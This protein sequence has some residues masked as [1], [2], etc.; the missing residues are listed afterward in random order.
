MNVI[1]HR[2]QSQLFSFAIVL[3]LVQPAGAQSPAA[4]HIASQVEKILSTDTLRSGFQ[5]VSIVRVDTGE[6]LCRRLSWHVFTPASNNKLLTSTG[7]LGILGSDFR[8]KTRVCASGNVEDSILKGNITLIGSGDP[9]L[10]TANLKELAQQTFSAGIHH[11]AGDVVA[12]V[13]CFDN[14]M[15]GTS[16]EWDDE[17]FYYAAQISGLNVDRNVAQVTIT[18]GKEVGE[19]PEV[20]VAPLVNLFEV[21]NYAV[22]EDTADHRPHIELTRERAANTLLI[23]GKIPPGKVAELEPVTFERPHKVAT[24]VFVQEFKRLGGEVDATVLPSQGNLAVIAEHISPPLSEILTLMNKPS[25][26]MIA[27]CLFKAVGYAASRKQGTSG[28]SGTSA[29]AIRKLLIGAGMK[30]EELRQVDGSGMARQNQISPDNL[31]RLLCWWYKRPEFLTLYASL[32]QAGVDG[33]LKS[34]MKGTSASGNCRAKTGSLTG[35]SCL[36]G[37]V[38]SADGVL[39]AFSIMTNAQIG[40]VRPCMEAQNRIVAMLA[41]SVIKVSGTHQTYSH[42]K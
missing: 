1:R 14:Q 37:Y 22:T 17:Q 25:D 18:G 11:I 27:E 36:S 21:K 42:R 6:P 9:V 40:S 28:A 34:R 15:L 32:P 7:A 2:I 19:V 41:N 13:S 29:L 24:G 39:L 35:V 10:T 20:T 3:L 4:K 26:N 5:G 31:T 30:P 16:W 23:T 33:T 12:D 8:F 38:K